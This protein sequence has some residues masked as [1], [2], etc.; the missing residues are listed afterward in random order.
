MNNA[1]TEKPWC[2]CVFPPPF[3]RTSIKSANSHI[4]RPPSIERLRFCVDDSR[5]C[6]HGTVID[7]PVGLDLHKA[8]DVCLSPASSPL[9]CGQSS[10]CF[11]CCSFYV[12]FYSLLIHSQVQITDSYVE[13]IN[14]FVS[15]VRPSKGK[16]LFLLFYFVS[17]TAFFL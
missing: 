8:D 4:L 16:T 5:W 7:R 13:K 12:L 11:Y 1:P 17:V 15:Q 9:Q 14:E 2:V 6:Q 3:R 10:C